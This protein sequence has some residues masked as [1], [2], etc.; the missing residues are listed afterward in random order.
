MVTEIHKMAAELLAIVWR[1]IPPHFKSR[2]RLTIWEQFENQVRSAA[3]TANLGKFVNSLC[4]KL[5]AAIGL[6]AA[7]REQ[8]DVILQSGQDRLLLKVFREETTLIVLM[9]RVANQE[10]RDDI[11]RIVTI[12]ANAGYEIAPAR[13]R[14]TWEN[15]SA[16]QG[17]TWLELPPGDS[18]ILAVIRLHTEKED[19]NLFV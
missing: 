9:V 10:R 4:L 8:A 6:N 15:W 11:E 2:Y 19:E 13:A 16:G 17:V 7:D 14:S 1:G 12:A 5:S 3:Y 18:E